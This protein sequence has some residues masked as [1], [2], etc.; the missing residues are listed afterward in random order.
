MTRATDFTLVTDALATLGTLHGRSMPPDRASAYFAALEDL[1][2]AHVLEAIRDGAREDRLPSAGWLYKR[3]V[4]LARMT[5]AGTPP[6]AAERARDHVQDITSWC[7]SYGV[8]LTKELLDAGTE[9]RLRSAIEE[10]ATCGRRDS[11]V[12]GTCAEQVP[13]PRLVDRFTYGAE[14]IQ[15]VYRDCPEHLARC[16]WRASRRVPEPKFGKRE[17][18]A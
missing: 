4:S 7:R 5:P 16:E 18:A 14:G 10:S 15:L 9:A 2:L 13:I 17:Q 3:A 8:D 1:P 6:P 11:C 12:K